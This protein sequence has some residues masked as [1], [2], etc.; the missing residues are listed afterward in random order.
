MPEPAAVQLR[1]LIVRSV[2][3]RYRE[4]ENRGSSSTPSRQEILSRLQKQEVTVTDKVSAQASF[5]SGAKGSFRYLGSGEPVF[6]HRHY[7]V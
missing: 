7:A 2:A 4:R 5:P 1:S 3:G 6:Q